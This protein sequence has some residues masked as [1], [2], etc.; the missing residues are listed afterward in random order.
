MAKEATLTLSGEVVEKLPNAQFRVELA[1][2]NRVILA[3]LSGKMKQHFIKVVVGDWVEVE[4]SPYDLTKG[5]VLTRLSTEEAQ[6]RSAEKRRAQIAAS[7][8]GN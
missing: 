4:L 8:T 2:V 1:Q 7:E 3:R 6:Q 5:R